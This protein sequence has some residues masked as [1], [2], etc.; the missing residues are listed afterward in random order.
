MF[1]LVIRKDKGD[2]ITIFFDMADTGLSN[3][4]LEYTKYL[5]SL[6]KYYYP[7][8]LN[9]ILVFEMPWVLNGMYTFCNNYYIINC[10]FPHTYVLYLYMFLHLLCIAMFEK[11]KR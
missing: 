5:I 9:Y 1:C 11:K 6:C 7:N 8:F 3:M 2:Q 4:D 10:Y